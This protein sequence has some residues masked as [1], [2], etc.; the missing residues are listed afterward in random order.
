MEAT[1]RQL[2]GSTF[3][4]RGDTNH[5]TVMDA[6]E[7]A[8][9]SEAATSPMELLLISLGGCTGID[10]NTLLKKM[11]V[12]YDD[13]VMEISGDR[14]DEHPKVFTEIRLTYKV[15]GK[16]V[17]EDKVAKAVD[18]TQERYCSVTHTLQ[19]PVEIK[20][21]YEIVDTDESKDWVES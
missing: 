18:L 17:P 14:R 13:I 5:W 6:S 19:D 9:G 20:Y 8:D 3:V 21:D 10:L 16:D 2:E 4:G 15:V 7:D 12:D 1:V 11:R